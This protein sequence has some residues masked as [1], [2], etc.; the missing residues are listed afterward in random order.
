MEVSK[1]ETREK[2]EDDVEDEEKPCVSS[3]E[4]EAF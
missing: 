1:V 4:C 3:C 2:E